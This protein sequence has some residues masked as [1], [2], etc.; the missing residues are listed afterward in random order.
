MLRNER[1][2]GKSFIRKIIQLAGWKIEW[3]Y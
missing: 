2:L 1:F 3:N